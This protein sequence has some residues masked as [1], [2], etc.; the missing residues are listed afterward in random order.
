MDQLEIT[1]E[2]EKFEINESGVKEQHAYLSLQGNPVRDV[3]EFNQS[4]D[5][6]PRDTVVQNPAL[7]MSQIKNH[8]K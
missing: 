8:E 6:I 2:S 1:P 4:D 5:D 3:S 7:L